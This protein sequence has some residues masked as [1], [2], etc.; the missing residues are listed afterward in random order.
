MSFCLFCHE[1]SDKIFAESKNKGTLVFLPEL[2]VALPEE[3]QQDTRA[4]IRHYIFSMP[5][6]DRCLA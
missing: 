3:W 1:M 2:N 4:V 6:T 5:D